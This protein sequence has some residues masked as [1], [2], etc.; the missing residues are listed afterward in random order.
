LRLFVAVNLPDQVKHRLGSILEEL[1]AFDLPIRW[2]DQD[3]LHITLKFLGEVKEPTDQVIKQALDVAV[4][5]LNSFDVAIG[6]FGV[7]PSAT[8]AR[9]FWLG[10]QPSSDLTMLQ[11]RVETE[12]GPLGFDREK[13]AFS[14]HIT[15]GRA[16]G[17]TSTI[18]R[19]DVDRIAAKVGYNANVRAAAA[20]LMR[21][22]LSP[23][24]AR[25]ELLHSA[26]L[27]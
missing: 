20:D 5:G 14:P 16:K 27:E 19:A 7:F 26:E 4:A 22:H 25:Y 12:L 1:R 6:G 24:G 23:Q 18:A 3:S 13:R 15:L 9:V 10:V 21:S 8:R 17:R 2:V 11:E